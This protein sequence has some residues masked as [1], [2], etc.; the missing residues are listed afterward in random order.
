MQQAKPKAAAAALRFQDAEHAVCHIAGA[1]Y[2][3]VMVKSSLEHCTLQ[4]KHNFLPGLIFFLV[5]R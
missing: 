1:G 5:M 3:C 2:F 4:E